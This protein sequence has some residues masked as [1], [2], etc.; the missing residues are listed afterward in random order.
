M[1]CMRWK[2]VPLCIWSTWDR[3]RLLAA[4]WLIAP[5]SDVE[6]STSFFTQSEELSTLVWSIVDRRRSY[7]NF[8]RPSHSWQNESSQMLPRLACMI[9][10]RVDNHASA[11]KGFFSPVFPFYALSVSFHPARLSNGF[12]LD[13]TLFTLCPPRANWGKS[14]GWW[15]ME[16]NAR[17]TLL[18][19]MEKN[20]ICDQTV[21]ART[22]PWILAES[23]Q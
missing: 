1:K 11:T 16:N 19:V 6:K 7:H 13:I 5:F 2:A 14:E 23:H 4:V 12:C 17:N 15:K 22:I 18:F 3:A 10:S 21:I 20:Y 9:W 8:H